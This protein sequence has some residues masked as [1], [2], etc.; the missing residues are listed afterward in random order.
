MS[1][2]CVVLNMNM[3]NSFHKYLTG[4]CG[5]QY[6]HEELCWENISPEYGVMNMNM[7]KNSFDK[8]LS[9]GCLIWTWIW[10]WQI[11]IW[12]LKNG[13]DKICHRSVGCWRP[14]GGRGR[15]TFCVRAEKEIDNSDK[16]HSKFQNITKSVGTTHLLV[17]KHFSD[18]KS[19][20]Q[21]FSSEILSNFPNLQQ[22]RHP[23]NLIFQIREYL[24][25]FLFSASKFHKIDDKI[26]V[27]VLDTFCTGRFVP[28]SLLLLLLVTFWRLWVS[29]WETFKL[30]SLDSSHSYFHDFVFVFVSCQY[31]SCKGAAIYV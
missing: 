11:N 2:K 3:T 15:H 10:I 20:L 9:V 30:I 27:R 5:L 1:P 23:D 8:Y 16:S 6:E 14:G 31:Q 4:V 7:K 22:Q 29:P 25:G 13:F 12:R 17:P 28:F 26:P 18:K 21:Q 24:N 19:I